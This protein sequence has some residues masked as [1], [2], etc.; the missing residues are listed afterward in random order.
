MA[1]INISDGNRH[2]QCEEADFSHFE[3]LG[4]KKTGKPVNNENE[5]KESEKQASS[6]PTGLDEPAKPDT[7]DVKKQKK[8]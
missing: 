6:K 3:A 2:R 8:K 5:A 4:Y 1:L 7:D